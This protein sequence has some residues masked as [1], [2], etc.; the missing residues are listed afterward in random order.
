MSWAKGLSQV[1]MMPSLQNFQ[2]GQTSVKGPGLECRQ[3]HLLD[4][5]QD[6]EGASRLRAPM[7]SSGQG[8]C[9]RDDILAQHDNE[10]FE[11]AQ[12]SSHV[13]DGSNLDEQ[14]RS[15]SSTC[16]LCQ[17]ISQL[18][19]Y[20]SDDQYGLYV[21]NLLNGKE[22]HMA[23][24]YPLEH[25]MMGLAVSEPNTVRVSRRRL[26]NLPPPME[27]I[28][29]EDLLVPA[30]TEYRLSEDVRSPYHAR[31]LDPAQ[32][33]FKS[34]KAWI[35]ECSILHPS[36]SASAASLSGT[37][38][39]I[40]CE[41]RI[42][43][44]LPD[45]SEYFALSYVWGQQ[46]SLPESADNSE[47][48]WP[49]KV[50]ANVPRTI[51]DAMAVTLALNHRYLW[52][53]RYCIDQN[54]P[55]AKA[56]QLSLMDKIYEAAKVT[57]VAASGV[58]DRYGLPGAGTRPL[59]SRDPQPQA[60]IGSHRVVPI[61][62]DIPTTVQQSKWATRAWT[63]QEARLSTRCL[64]FG[65]RQ[66][67]F[68]C[69][70]TSRYET[71]PRLPRL[72]NYHQSG[73]INIGSVFGGG[74][75]DQASSTDMTILR[76]FLSLANEYLKRDITFE[77]DTLN[78]FRGMLNRLEYFSFFGV[79]LITREGRDL[80]KAGT[81][82]L[83]SSSDSPGTK[84]NQ[85]ATLS[86]SKRI[87]A[88]ST[89]D[90]SKKRRRF[91]YFHEGD[92]HHYMYDEFPGPGEPMQPCPTLAF[93]HGLTWIR[94]ENN[95]RDSDEGNSTT[96]EVG[97]RSD[98]PS[99][100]WV[101]LRKGPFSYRTDYADGKEI[102][103]DVQLN[104][105]NGIQV[106]V[107][108]KSDLPQIEWISI[109]DTWRQCSGKVLPDFGRQI[110]LETL[111]SD[112]ESCTVTMPKFNRNK[113]EYTITLRSLTA[114]DGHKLILDLD[115]ASDNLPVSGPGIYQGLGWKI[116]LIF[117]T[118]YYNPDYEDAWRDIEPRRDYLVLRPVDSIWK[119]VGIMTTNIH[120]GDHDEGVVS[121][122]KRETLILY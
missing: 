101:S 117:S 62:P 91:N 5:W 61:G 18:P 47:L 112:V 44:P 81:G 69:K 100:S 120:F 121:V 32:A 22:R 87:I 10:L 116:A 39:V 105:H 40:D 77:S 95:W 53:D 119:R 28:R 57:L 31:I 27:G 63:F 85:I 80:C 2:R 59:V 92:W 43:L 45:D 71:L 26:G 16:A 46:P 21:I 109:D 55:V 11:P 36:C 115:C 29:R 6:Q 49:N 86:D 24:D 52:C 14:R 65:P 94:D 110:K 54:D 70:T 72:I 13:F 97:R 122:L 106:W 37:I 96:A 78:A 66:L 25:F 56:F 50:P 12:D 41:S 58:D 30:E 103:G 108:Q 89:L 114:T 8:L 42:I 1:H 98:M 99:W 60:W 118:S 38:H 34:A 73:E 7:R 102:S 111:T 83:P 93:L 88:S 3:T 23:L 76:S 64:I 79:P 113:Y 51:T 17:P 74:T 48:T 75:A 84:S 82:D 15:A 104:L 20:S 68:L 33:D 107:Q 4:I 19:A 67:Q 90:P 35:Q 9:E